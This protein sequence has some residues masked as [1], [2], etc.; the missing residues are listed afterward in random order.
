VINSKCI[1]KDLFALRNLFEVGGE[2][3]LYAVVVVS[4]RP[5]ASR[6][7]D[8]PYWAT[9]LVFNL[10]KGISEHYYINF[11]SSVYRAIEFQPGK[12]NKNLF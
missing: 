1:K 3:F 8:V 5:L 12:I 11:P 10:I 4:V 2:G 7:D 9:Q 6:R